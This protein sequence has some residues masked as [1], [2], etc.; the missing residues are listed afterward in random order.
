MNYSLFNS[1]LQFT[2]Q[3]RAAA[4][5]GRREVEPR[6][7]P[8]TGQLA[9]AGLERPSALRA[10]AQRAGAGAAGLCAE[11]HGGAGRPH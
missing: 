5:P 1:V 6:R 9:G 3:V 10:D 2:R 4:D 11:L 7:A 8:S